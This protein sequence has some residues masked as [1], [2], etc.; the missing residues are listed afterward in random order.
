MHMLSTQV[1]NP[2]SHDAPTDSRGKSEVLLLC[3]K[4]E[5]E[6][7][8]KIKKGKNSIVGEKTHMMTLWC[9]TLGVVS[10]MDEVVLT[11]TRSS[12]SA[13]SLDL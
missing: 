5:K 11:A 3:G 1:L 10:G 12:S 8:I 4:K 6:K 9:E 2:G 7:E 13:S